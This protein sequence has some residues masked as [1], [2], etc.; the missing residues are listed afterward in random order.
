ME[1][2][3]HVPGLLPA[4][5]DR[6]RW[7]WALLLFCRAVVPVPDWNEGAYLVEGLGHCAAASGIT[8]PTGALGRSMPAFGPQMS[9]AEITALVKFLRARFSRGE[10]WKE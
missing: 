5:S 9:K 3:T 7:Q 4:R 8:P 6:D 2:R 10:P 1:R